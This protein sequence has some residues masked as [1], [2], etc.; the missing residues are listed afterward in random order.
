MPTADTDPITATG[1]GHPATVIADDN[2][3]VLDDAI[4]DAFTHV[5]R[6]PTVNHTIVDRA[7]DHAEQTLSS[8]IDD[9]EAWDG[10][11]S[12]YHETHGGLT[13]TVWIERHDQQW[14]Y[15]GAKV[16]GNYHYDNN[17]N[18]GHVV[19]P[20]TDAVIASVLAAHG[21]EFAERF[22]AAHGITLPSDATPST[23]WSRHRSRDTFLNELV[24]EIEHGPALSRNE[25]AVVL[26]V[27]VSTLDGHPAMDE[28]AAGVRTTELRTWID[29]HGGPNRHAMLERLD[30]ISAARLRTAAREVTLTEA[31]TLLG[32][33]CP[34]VHLSRK[35][36][37]LATTANGTTVDSVIELIER[38]RA[39]R[40][41]NLAPAIARHLAEQLTDA[42]PTE[43][44]A[45]L[46]DT[47]TD[48][49]PPTV[50][51]VRAILNNSDTFRVTTPG[52]F[53]L[54]DAQ[55]MDGYS[56]DVERLRAANEALTVKVG[57]E[58]RRADEAE[59]ELA[60][61]RRKVAQLAE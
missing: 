1:N 47:F 3:T 5:G 50:Q 42:S 25:I 40:R 13:T 38:R 21:T 4:V 54:A 8:V 51:S 36:G 55:P 11:S 41:R 48:G 28:L 57:D 39:N 10:A 26:G 9:P 29:G 33:T 46:Q 32:V 45:A 18:D 20:P 43:I 23:R 56:P 53:G 58:A 22:M 61:L 44:A 24:A 52:R 60:A 19:I 59:T 27:T 6:R 35:H 15:L 2:H 17:H 37:E 16:T 30:W 34:S 49:P 7:V 14:L 31:A 12:H